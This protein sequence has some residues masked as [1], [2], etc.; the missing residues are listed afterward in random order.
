[1]IAMKVH[2][3]GDC[4]SQFVGGTL[5][6]AGLIWVLSLLTSNG[7]AAVVTN[8]ANYSPV[9]EIDGGTATT[10]LSIA[11]LGP[12]PRIVKV[13]TTI[14][15]TKGDDPISPNGDPLGSGFSFNDEIGLALISPTGTRVA[16]Q[17]P[18]STL[19]GQAGGGARVTWT[20]DDSALA[21]ISG[22]QLISGTYQPAELLSLFNFENGNGTWILEYEDTA[23]GDPLTINSW[24]LTVA[25]VPEPTTF[26]IA[27]A[28]VACG[29]LAK[30][31]RRKLCQ[32]FAK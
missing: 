28:G 27:L 1:L 32:S 10:S 8:S 31:R 4:S 13:T 21:T 12:D 17:I 11:G 30:W 20:F 22:D 3:F 18:D 9:L 24:S 2:G 15:L 25:S 19:D 26:T 7:L 16:L 6:L 5:R 29:G 23:G 14:N